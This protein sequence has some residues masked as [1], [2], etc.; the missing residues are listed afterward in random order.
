MIRISFV[1]SD[2]SIALPVAAVNSQNIQISGFLPI[3]FLLKLPIDKLR[4]VWYNG[5]NARLGRWRA[6]EKSI[7]KNR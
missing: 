4:G 3:G 2:Y 6:A 7:V 1:L 5:N